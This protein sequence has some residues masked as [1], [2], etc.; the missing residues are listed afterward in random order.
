MSAV[1]VS[2][3]PTIVRVTKEGVIGAVVIVGI[4]AIAAWALRDILKF[5]SGVISKPTETAAPVA[6]K[7]RP[8]L[9]HWTECGIDADPRQRLTFPRLNT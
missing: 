7:V 5:G 9:A 4:L 1:E 6:L 3:G 8:P 2:V